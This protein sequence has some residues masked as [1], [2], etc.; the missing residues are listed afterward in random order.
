MLCSAMLTSLSIHP[1]ALASGLVEKAV[2]KGKFLL[3]QAALVLSHLTLQNNTEIW[4]GFMTRACMRCSVEQLHAALHSA[5]AWLT[6]TL[7]GQKLVCRGLRPVAN[8]KG[9]NSVSSDLRCMALAGWSRGSLQQGGLEQ[10][11]SAQDDSAEGSLAQ[12]HVITSS[13][14]ATMS[15]VHFDL[16]THR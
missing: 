12:A 3:V 11:R 14:D 1:L 15:L 13:S 4:K 9:Q 6:C 16:R 10:G 2:A 8:A 7:K 5:I